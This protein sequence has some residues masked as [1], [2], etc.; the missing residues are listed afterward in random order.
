MGRFMSKKSRCR[1]ASLTLLDLAAG[2]AVSAAALPAL[3]ADMPTKAPPIVAPAYNWTGFYVGGH[4]GYRWADA[5]LT[6]D[7]YIFTPASGALTVPGRNENYKPNGVIAGIHGGYNYMMSPQWLIGAEGDWTWGNSRDSLAQTITGIDS[8]GS[9]GFTLNRNSEVTLSWQATLRGRLGYVTG[10]WLI[11]GTGGVAFARVKW[12]E[13]TVLITTGPLTVST[14]AW[15]DSKILTGWVAGGGVEY[16]FLKNW[17]G[18]LEYLYESFGDFT[19]PT[20]LVPP[21]SPPR[22]GNLDLSG[23][24]KVRV[25]ISYKFNP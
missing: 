20:G 17:I 22:P 14:S 23:V 2:I 11:Y 19:V 8:S 12:N 24:Q 3:A 16:M 21:G 18:R 25:G 13:N 9:D 6:A 7:P 1:L 10:P 15:S 4:V 5:D